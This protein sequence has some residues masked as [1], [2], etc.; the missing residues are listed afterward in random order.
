MQVKKKK[1]LKRDKGEKKKRK[2]EGR[3]KNER[4]LSPNHGQQISS[5]E[6]W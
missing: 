2:R 3:Q 5:T 1:T 4:I 6:S